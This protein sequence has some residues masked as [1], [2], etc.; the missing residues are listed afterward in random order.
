MS[1]YK[2]RENHSYVN[3]C[4][5]SNDGHNLRC[6]VPCKVK[7]GCASHT[8]GQLREGMVTYGQPKRS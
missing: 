8:K 2:S 4:E 6:M 7:G 5:A 3:E 1:A